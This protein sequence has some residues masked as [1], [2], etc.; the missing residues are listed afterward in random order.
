MAEAGKAVRDAARQ[1]APWVVVLAR[2]GYASR[3]VVYLLIALLAARAAR[4]SGSPGGTRE[5]MREVE[6]QPAGDWMLVL[7]AVGL[8]GF[9]L[10]RFVQA[11]LDPEGKG[12]DGQ[13][14]GAAHRVRYAVSGVLHAALAMAAWQGGRGGGEDAWYADALSPLGRL[15][16]GAAALGFLGYGVYQAYRAYQVD[17]DDQLD[18]SRVSAGTRAWLVR[19]GRAGLT[20]RGVVFA[21]IGILLVQ[22]ALGG[23]PEESP[24]LQ[25]A[26][27]TLREQPF[28]PYLLGLMAV[29]LAGYG[30]FELARARY[31]RIRPG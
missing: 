1:A 3:G 15:A 11:A 5:A 21:V 12:D 6:R 8:A 28:G 24:G 4:G 27:R 7:L 13:A 26:L 22:A 10:W 29:G 20:A 30:V 18:L 16:V 17:L 9:A 14:A 23:G 19:A 31:R 25:G 2:A